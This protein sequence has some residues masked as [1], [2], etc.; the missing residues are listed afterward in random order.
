[1]RLSYSELKQR[2]AANP[3]T[4]EA[5]PDYVSYFCFMKVKEKKKSQLL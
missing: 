3:L 2:K 1:M 5:K 4:G